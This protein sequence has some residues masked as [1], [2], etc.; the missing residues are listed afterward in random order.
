MLNEIVV[1]LHRFNF[2][3][4]IV[5]FNRLMDQLHALGYCEYVE[6]GY[7]VRPIDGEYFVTATDIAYI[8]EDCQ[9]LHDLVLC[10][11][12]SSRSGYWLELPI[13][14]RPAARDPAQDVAPPGT[15]KLKQAVHYMIREGCTPYA[16][17]KACGVAPS[18]MYITIARMRANGE[19]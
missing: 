18:N 13:S 11:P 3:A 2:G 16:A 6:P 5:G 19:I 10:Q 1:K 14:C 12:L 15:S 17:A 9:T 8:T 4:D 7:T